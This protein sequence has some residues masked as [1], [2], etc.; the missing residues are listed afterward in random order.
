MGDKG[1]MAAEIQQV[2]EQYN[3]NDPAS[4]MRLED[5]LEKV[6]RE[7]V[8]PHIF[9]MKQRLQTVNNV[10]IVVALEMGLLQTLTANQGKSL[11]V[12]DLSKAS[13]YNAGL[14]ARVMRIITAIG[15]ANETA[16]QTYSANGCTLA[17]NSPGG[18][19]GII[20]SNDIVFPVASRIRQYLRQ[21]KPVDISKAPPAYEFALGETIWQTLSKNNEWKTGFDDNMTARNKTLSIPWHVKYPVMEKLT[22]WSLSTKPI[23]VDVGGNQGVD[24]QRFADTFPDLECEL[25][26]QDLPETIAGIPGELDPRIRPTAHDFFTEQTTKGAHIY[27]LK[28]ILHDWDDVASRKIL[29]NIAKVMQPHSRLLINEMILA[30]LNESMIRSNMDMLMLFFT[31]G[32][33]RTQTQW[34]ELLATVE[35]PLEIVQVYSAQGDQQ[36]VIETCLAQ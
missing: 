2:I 8:P 1:S 10:C 17:Q 35:P 32:M 26:L 28:S 36:C 33:E 30:D 3:K 14:I 13:G 4:W 27:Y 19:G 29:S 18:I 15:F 9:T 7:L 25:I 31:N 23:I 16:Y 5:A 6:R 21:N 20:I 24:L 22:A 12:E 11:T 34:N